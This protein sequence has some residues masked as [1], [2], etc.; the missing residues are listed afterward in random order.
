MKSD[1]AL[2]SVS[3]T[4]LDVYKRQKVGCLG[5]GYPAFFCGAD[6]ACVQAFLNHRI[7]FNHIPILLEKTLETT[8]TKPKSVSDVIDIYN[9]GYKTAKNLIQQRR[10]LKC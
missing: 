7:R 4:H 2:E 1:R 10:S 3:Y 8:I 9:Q 5:G 6:E